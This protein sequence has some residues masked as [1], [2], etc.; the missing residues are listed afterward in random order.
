MDMDLNF[1]ECISIEYGAKL[2]WID[3]KNATTKLNRVETKKSNSLV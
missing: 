3:K 2:G 1:L